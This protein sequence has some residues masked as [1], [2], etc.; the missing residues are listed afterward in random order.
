MHAA[1]CSVAFTIVIADS[2]TSSAATSSLIKSDLFQG[3][4]SE[5]LHES[6]GSKQP[7]SESSVWSFGKGSRGELG[8]GDS[9]AVMWDPV[10]ID[11]LRGKSVVAVSTGLKHC[12]ALT[13]EV[14][15]ICCLR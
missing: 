7:I 5:I 2:V 1:S 13:A 12:A 14:C 11:S 15:D 9:F 8:I 6:G 10:E 3:L 4:S